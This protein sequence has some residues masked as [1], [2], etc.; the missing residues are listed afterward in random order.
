MLVVE[1]VIDARLNRIFVTQTF[2]RW[3]GGVAREM[4]ADAWLAAT[5]TLT[6]QESQAIEVLRAALS[7]AED[8]G[9]TLIRRLVRDDQA[10]VPAVRRATE[11]LAPRAARIADGADPALR[12]WQQY[13]G[14]TL[15]DWY[16][17]IR[18]GIDRFFGVGGVH[19]LRVYLLPSAAGWTSGNGSMFVEQGATNV[20]CSGT[21]PD[22]P[23]PV[24]TTV[25]HEGLHSI[26][27]A[28]L[29]DPIVEAVL[30]T[31][32]GQRLEALRRRSPLRMN[33]G[34][35]VGELVIHALVP[36]GVLG[37]RCRGASIA[38][39]WRRTLERGTGLLATATS[40]GDVYAAWVM[41]G[42]AR[43]VP[44]AARWIDQ[45]RTADEALVRE[46]LGIFEAT[47]QAWSAAQASGAAAAGAG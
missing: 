34:S 7:S 36:D 35:Y 18:A 28:Q 42:A 12:H 16:D 20:D 44:V 30:A 1:P 43:M 8:D 31:P 45:G 24:L 5:G 6:A 37:E 3:H 19:R 23:V 41:A 25:L 15:P 39:H 14:G 22:R 47:H 4:Y 11:V 40:P 26:Y 33:L 38:D 29:L 32:C 13:L 27:Q 21:P 2:A 46:A 17:C 10:L 9:C